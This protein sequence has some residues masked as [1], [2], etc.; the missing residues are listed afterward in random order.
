VR[1][2]AAALALLLI[3]LAAIIAFVRLWGDL[4]RAIAAPG[5]LLLSTATAW[6]AVTR[7]G[8]A[9]LAAAAATVGVLA[10]LVAL[11]VTAEDHGIAI[12]VVVLLLAGSTA[13]VP[14]ALR[15]DPQSLERQPVPGVRV[16][17]ARRGVL[18][19]NPRSGDGKV[20]RFDL[21]DECRRRGIE[22]VVLQ[23]GDDLLE[24]AHRAIDGGADVIGMAGGDGSQALVAGAASAAGIPM[25]CVPAGTRNHFA[26]DLGLDRDDVVAA[27]D[28][29]ADGASERRIDLA[30]VNGHV[31]V[32]NV[33]LGVYAAIVQSSSYRAAKRRTTA[34]MLADLVGPDAEPFDL[35]FR[36]PDG[37]PFDDARVIQISN[38]PYELT[39]A[40]AF[41]SRARLDTGKLGIA[42]ATV[43][44]AKDVT[45]L[46]A[47]EWL[48]RLDD[49]EGWT[50]WEADR[51]TVTSGGPV[52]AAVDGEAFRLDP[53]LEFRIRPGALRVR[54]PA[55]APGYAPAALKSPSMGWTV[56]ALAQTALGRPPAPP[57]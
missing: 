11:I 35:H 7:R 29:F 19:A 18:L 47:A 46:V 8:A 10:L 1:R 24:L 9:R 52:D 34:A 23:E 33:S 56:R 43:R 12:F 28:G 13:L 51:F 54:I 3:A 14:Y 15:R 44:G 40:T 36:S 32:N 21:V 57:G 53:P 4:A 49:L 39:S 45:E 38:N 30:E 22:I 41:G 27:L 16:G 17:A 50:R 31:F 55:S 20:E 2:A 37:E 25:V 42:A 6:T 5:L 26:L 48:H